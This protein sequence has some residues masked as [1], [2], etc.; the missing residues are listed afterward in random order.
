MNEQSGLHSVSDWK[1]RWL[2]KINISKCKVVYLTNISMT[3]IFTTYLQ[4]SGSYSR[5]CWSL[6]QPW[7][8]IWWKT[9]IQ[10]ACIKN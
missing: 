9:N 8:F 2:M 4:R 10:R 7:G 5:T 1:N 3:A 6:Q